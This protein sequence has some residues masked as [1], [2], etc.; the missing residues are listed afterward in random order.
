M[1][2]CQTCAFWEN[3]E[4][5]YGILGLC[6]HLEFGNFV[7]VVLKDSTVDVDDVKMLVHRSFGCILWGDIDE[8]P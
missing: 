8:K 4:P 7:E 5:E 2:W 3:I 1:G 6:K